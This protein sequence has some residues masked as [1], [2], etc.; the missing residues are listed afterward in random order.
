MPDSG[1]MS[2]PTTG[3][4]WIPEDS[5]AARLLL[6]R[7]HL[8]ISVKEAAERCHVH[9]ATWSTWERG[10]TPQ[11]YPTV[12]LRVAEGLGVNRD[13]LAWGGSLAAVATS[14]DQV[15]SVTK[16]YRMGHFSH[17]GARVSRSVIGH[18]G[19][20][21]SVVRPIRSESGTQVT[22]LC[23]KIAA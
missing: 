20:S 22:N 7:R 4:G 23:R 17:I 16:R 19:A 10:A 14:T 1:G 21:R 11:N 6:A 5:F 12:V 8:G 13:W 15:A 9:Y 3:V 18:T 2:T